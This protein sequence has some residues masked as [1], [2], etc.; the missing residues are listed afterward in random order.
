KAA[1]GA[2]KYITSTAGN[3]HSGAN[4]F[5]KNRNKSINMKNLKIQTQGE[6]VAPQFNAKRSNIGSLKTGQFPGTMPIQALKG[7][8]SKP[9]N[10]SL[11]TSFKQSLKRIGFK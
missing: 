1:V 5:L 4:S 7:A 6:L 9:L 2:K 10:N 3:I 8:E 11:S